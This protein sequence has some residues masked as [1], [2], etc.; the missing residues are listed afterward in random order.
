MEEPD[1]KTP[2]PVLEKISTHLN[3]IA[4]ALE[5]GR[6]FV[7]EIGRTVNY[8]WLALCVLGLVA[9]A[10]IVILRSRTVSE[11]TQCVV[12]QDNVYG[13]AEF[14]VKTELAK[15]LKLKDEIG[16]QNLIASGKALP[17]P[18]DT[19][20]LVLDSTDPHQDEF[21]Y[22]LE[23]WDLSHYYR[24]RVLSG[25]A[26]GKAVWIPSST[27]HPG[28][29]EAKAQTNSQTGFPTTKDGGIDWS[30]IKVVPKK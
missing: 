20:C 28:R 10:K 24:I 18:K 23:F 15:A 27:L 25:A 12:A 8:L 2:T 26:Y 1:S 21:G 16:V 29:S 3:R 5:A 9:G 22:I 6:N 11:G 14:K 19:E 17:L 4:N 13:V 7:K 30:K